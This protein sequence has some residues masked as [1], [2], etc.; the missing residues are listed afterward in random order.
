MKLRGK[1]KQEDGKLVDLICD[2]TN[3]VINN[4]IQPNKIKKPR[5]DKPRHPN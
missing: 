4:G 3:A 5:H 1:N 2:Q